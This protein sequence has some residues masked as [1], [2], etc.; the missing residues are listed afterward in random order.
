[1][2][3]L[4]LGEI[5]PSTVAVAFS[6]NEDEGKVTLR[7][8]LDCQLTYEDKEVVSVILTELLASFSFDEH[9]QVDKLIHECEYLSVDALKGEFTNKDEVTLFLRSH[10]WPKLPAE[11]Y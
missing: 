8:Y 9:E 1:M 7:Y 6:F 3:Y 4:L 10:H 11:L 5:Y 2:Y